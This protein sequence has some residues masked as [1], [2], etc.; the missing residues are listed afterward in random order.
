MGLSRT[1]CTRFSRVLSG[2]RKDVLEERKMMIVD[3]E[4]PS[5]ERKYQFSLEEQVTVETLI[6][7]LAE[8]L[9]QKEQCDLKGEVESLCLCSK[10]QKRILD[11]YTTLAQQGVQNADELLL[12]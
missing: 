3:I 11:R 5:L 1:D 10:E 7:E 2:N 4:V 12:V 6:A 8:V 9:C